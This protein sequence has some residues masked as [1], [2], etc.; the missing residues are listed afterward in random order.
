MSRC[1]ECNDYPEGAVCTYALCPGKSR[2]T[3]PSIPDTGEEWP[4][5]MLGPIPYRPVDFADWREGLVSKSHFFA[6][7]QQGATVPH[8]I[9]A[10]PI[11]GGI[12][13]KY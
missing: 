3:A 10:V 11:G 5:R 1:T 6:L 7:T 2:S 12:A 13:P 4:F 8:H 9:G